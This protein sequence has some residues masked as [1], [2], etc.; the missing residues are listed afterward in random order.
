MRKFLLLIMFSMCL[1]ALF[2]PTASAQICNG[3]IASFSNQ[4]DVWCD[5]GYGRG[6][7]ATPS[8]ATDCAYDPGQWVC[9]GGFMMLMTYCEVF[10]V[11]WLC[12]DFG[13]GLCFADTTMAIPSESCTLYL[14]ACCC[15]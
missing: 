6:Y 9:D 7:W 14:A 15:G 11:Q 3:M 2:V 5:C 10:N 1:S 8:F 12:P 4:S 13:Q